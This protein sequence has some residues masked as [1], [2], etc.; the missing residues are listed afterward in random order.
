MGLA[1]IMAYLKGTAPREI[2][3][4]REVWV[5]YEIAPGIEMHIRRDVEEKEG[6]KVSDLIRVAKS[7]TRETGD[8]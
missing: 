1:A 6:K 4:V 8:E 3:Y 7:Y 2:P 5:K